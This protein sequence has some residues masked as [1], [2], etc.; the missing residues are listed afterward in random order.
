MDYPGFTYIGQ[1]WWQAITYPFASTLGIELL[2][3]LFTFLGF[4]MV[5]VKTKSPALIS[6]LII[7][8]SPI[9]WKY[10]P[11]SLHRYVLLAV[12]GGVAYIIIKVLK[13]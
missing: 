5:Y 1:D 2:I 10:V 7:V 11:P 8:L 12:A 3:A 4:T 6:I 13:G 9:V